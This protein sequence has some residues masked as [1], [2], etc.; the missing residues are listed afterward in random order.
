MDSFDKQVEDFYNAVGNKRTPLS[1]L[2]RSYVHQ[3][4]KFRNNGWQC[5]AAWHSDERIGFGMVAPDR[6]LSVYEV[7]AIDVCLL[8]A[9]QYVAVIEWQTAHPHKVAGMAGIQYHPDGTLYKKLWY[10]FWLECDG[11]AEQAQA[12]YEDRLS[13]THPEIGL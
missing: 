9:V 3:V 6:S 8:E 4:C 1:G 2:W 12:M 5:Y 11:D 13:G 7:D 10:Q